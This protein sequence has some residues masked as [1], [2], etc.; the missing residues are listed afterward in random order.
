MSFDTKTPIWGP[1]AEFSLAEALAQKE[2]GDLEFDSPR[3]GEGFP[4]VIDLTDDA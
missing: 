1:V 2:G 3:M 4:K